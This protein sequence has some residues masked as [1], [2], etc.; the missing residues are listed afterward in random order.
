LLKLIIRKSRR[1]ALSRL[2]YEKTIA[3]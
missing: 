1:G 2:I 3:S